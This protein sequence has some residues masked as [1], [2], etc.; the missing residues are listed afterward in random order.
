MASKYR[1]E[2]IKLLFGCATSCAYPDCEQPLVFWDR[3]HPTVAAEIAHIRSEKQKGPRHDPAYEGD[4]NGFENLLLLCATHH[5]PVDRHESL[6]TV[7]ELEEWKALQVAQ[8]GQQ[9]GPER[10]TE[11]VRQVQRSLQKLTE[12]H[13]SV[14][15]IGGF[16]VG[17]LD[18][19]PCPLSGMAEVT[20][21]EADGKTYLGLHVSNRGLVSVTV[22][23]VGVDFDLD[24]GDANPTA[25]FPQMADLGGRVRWQ[26][27]KRLN[28]HDQGL[29]F[30][31]TSWFTEAVRGVRNGLGR[32]PPQVR[33]YAA[34]GSG[35]VFRGEWSP[36]ADVLKALI[37]SPG[38]R[39]L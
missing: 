32:F 30:V 29:W 38:S 19:L 34:I 3:G 4:I 20:F 11:V 31:P 39:D 26:P 7:T 37:S 16:G 2:T 35:T 36:L 25:R 24:L 14:D 5:K 27:T 23:A 9:V 13:L 6:Y 1:D 28:G 8:A 15:L 12:V 17:R 18:I 22:T 21:E 10:L 33:P